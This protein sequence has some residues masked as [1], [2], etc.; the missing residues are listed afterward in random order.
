MKTTN[1]SCGWKIQEYSLIGV[2]IVCIEC[3]TVPWLSSGDERR[4]CWDCKKVIPKAMLD[5]AKEL[6]DGRLSFEI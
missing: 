6:L 1:Y 3:N 5:E 4:Y 2:G